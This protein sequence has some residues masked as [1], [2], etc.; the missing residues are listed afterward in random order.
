MKKNNL[1]TTIT[2]FSML[3]CFSL[4]AQGPPGGGGS[5]GGG[6]GRGGQKGGPPEASEILSKLDTNKDNY[7]DKDE[8]AKDKR[9]KISEDFEVIDSNGD[10]LIDL[11][12]LDASLND[13]KPKKVSPKKLIKEVDD[14]GDGTLNELE[15]AA[16]GE[17]E[18][19]DDFS[20]IDTNEDGELDIEEL[21][22]FFEKN[23]STKKSKRKKRD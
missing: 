18:L 12:E 10:E 17:K 20:A 3:L 14:N 5:R 21:K 19:S 7:I 8:A 23:V 15:V 4:F 11:E 13:R 6:Q 1:K 16:K 9:G 2:I 22:A